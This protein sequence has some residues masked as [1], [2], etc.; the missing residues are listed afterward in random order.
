MWKV[1]EK[2]VLEGVRKGKL[3]IL[4]VQETHMKGCSV[5]DCMEASE[6]V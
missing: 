4:E 3:D 1:R 5:M 2:E 6:S